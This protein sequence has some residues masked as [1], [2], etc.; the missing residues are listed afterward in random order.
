MLV[1]PQAKS[2]FLIDS[3]MT[4]A[5]STWLFFQL[6]NIGEYHRARNAFIVQM[7]ESH[8]QY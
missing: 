2:F 7:I 1:V 3:S 8:A 4:N 6:T 5:A